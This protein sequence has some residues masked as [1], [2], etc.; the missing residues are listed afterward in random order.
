MLTRGRYVHCIPDKLNDSWLIVN[1]M[2][3]AVMRV[4]NADFSTAYAVL[5]REIPDDR[6]TD[7]ERSYMIVFEENGFL[8]DSSIDEIGVLERQY[9][10]NKHSPQF[11]SVAIVTG[12]QC[13]LRCTYC[14]QDHVDEY[15]SESDAHRIKQNIIKR[16]SDNSELSKLHITWWG[17]E[18]LLNTAPIKII[19]PDV[20]NLCNDRG[21]TY[22]SY[23]STNGVLL[24][25]DNCDLLHKNKVGLLQITID[26]PRRFHDKQRPRVGG[27]PTYDAIFRGLSNVRSRWGE[28]RVIRLR[29]NVAAFETECAEEWDNFFNDLDPFHNLISLSFHKTIASDFLREDETL[30]N[31]DYKKFQKEIVSQYETRFHF[32]NFSGGAERLRTPG[33]LFCGAIHDNNMIVLPGNRL[34]KCTAGFHK[35]DKDYGF[36]GLNGEEIVSNEINSWK[37]YSPFNHDLCKSC[38]VLPTCMGGCNILPFSSSKSERCMIKN[39]IEREVVRRYTKSRKGE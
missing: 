14:Y 19:A 24:N 13:N 32:S 17:G 37:Q 30:D 1:L 39:D 11:A 2:T 35:R 7:V 29:V 31:E 23:I 12:L 8:I 27:Q 22:T 34:T 28:E 4:P 9:W 36:L 20:I 18:P 33:S 10:R 38:D 21:I 26:G 3:N 5:S 16:I 15:V 25:N 6:M